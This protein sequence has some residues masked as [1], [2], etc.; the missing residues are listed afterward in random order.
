MCHSISEQVQQRINDLLQRGSINSGMVAFENEFDLFI[1]LGA[2][3]SHR[4]M[5]AGGNVRQWH[6]SQAHQAILQFGINSALAVE[7][8]QEV[9]IEMP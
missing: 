4:A 6:H 9:A 5:Q 2:D 7:V 3:G 1:F 8:T